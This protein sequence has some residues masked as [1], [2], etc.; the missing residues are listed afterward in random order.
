MNPFKN[1]SVEVFWSL[2]RQTN[3]PLALDMLVIPPEPAYP[4]IVKNRNSNAEF[5][6]CPAIA[7]FFKNTFLIRS[8]IDLE[9]Y[10]TPE[11]D[12][13]SDKMDN[14][15]LESFIRRSKSSNEDTHKAFQVIT[16][17]LVFYTKQDIEVQQLPAFLEHSESQNNVKT[18]PGVFNISK[19]VRPVSFAFEVVDINK[20]VVI[21]R[22]DPM[23]YL[24]FSVPDGV[25]VILKQEDYLEDLHNLTQKCLSLKSIRPKI[26]LKENYSL[27]AKS[28]ADFWR[29]RK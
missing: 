26:S 12:A 23:Y 13:R 8:P 3:Q 22:G 16:S 25:K 24:K 11:G 7:A 14:W 21:K 2:A 6:L 28:I 17:L 15:Y 1:K 4:N 20:P 18:I 9:F 5:T 29:K 10:A 27:A 19:W